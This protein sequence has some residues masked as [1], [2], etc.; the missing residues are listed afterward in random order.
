[1]TIALISVVAVMA[2]VSLMAVQVQAKKH[3]DD[4][5]PTGSSAMERGAADATCSED[6]NCDHLYITQPGK[7]FGDHSPEFNHNY[8]KGWCAAAHGGGSD[9]DEATFDCNRDNN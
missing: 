8:I 7:G 2:S 4:D 9:A 3:H 6:N 1:M 5:K